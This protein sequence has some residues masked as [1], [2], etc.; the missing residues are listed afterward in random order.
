MKLKILC[1]INQIKYVPNII[2]YDVLNVLNRQ[3]EQFKI[4][5]TY[6]LKRKFKIR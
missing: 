3:Y 1:T 2:N 6:L 5:K 4:H